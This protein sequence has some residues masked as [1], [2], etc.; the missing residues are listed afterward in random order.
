MTLRGARLLKMNVP[1]E[2]ADWHGMTAENLWVAELEH[3]KYRIEN[4]PLYAY[5]L[6][7]HDVVSGEPDQDGRLLFREV[8]IQGGHSNY[9]VL[10]RSGKTVEDFIKYWSPLGRLGC[11]YESSKDPEDVFAID[12]P[13]QT[14]VNEVYKVL[15]LGDQAGVWLFD[16]GNFEPPQPPP[17]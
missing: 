2:S 4:N 11:S 5:G 8:V 16:E 13:P 14:D 15:E 1:T 12:V 10:L 3:G 17:T 6:S 7:Y 9:R